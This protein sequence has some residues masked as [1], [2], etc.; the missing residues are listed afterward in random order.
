M[1]PS[2][3]RSG[4]RWNRK[5]YRRAAHLARFFTRVIELPADP[6]QLLRRYF[7]LWEDHPQ[8][9]DPLLTPMRYRDHYLGDDIPF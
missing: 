4:F 9:G 1:H 2:P 6:P 3:A 5:K 7:E 8:K